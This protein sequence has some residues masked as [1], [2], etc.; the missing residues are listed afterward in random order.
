MDSTYKYPIGALANLFPDMDENIFAGLVRS[1]REDGLREPILVSRGE[2]VDGRHRYRACLE[3]GVE[4]RFER[5][6]DDTDPMSFVIA[7]NILRRQLSPSQLAVIA[8]RLT[9]L[10]LSDAGTD[11]GCAILHKPMTQR[12]A[13]D[14]LGV[15]LRSLH[16][17]RTVLA[18]DSTAAPELR[19]AVE[20]G[21]VTVSDAAKIAKEPPDVQNAALDQV[22]KGASNNLARAAKQIAAFKAHRESSIPVSRSADIRVHPPVFHR[23]AVADLHKF[24]KAGSVDAIIT[25]PPLTEWS[26]VMYSHLADFAVHALTG[27]GCM[28]VMVDGVLLPRIMDAIRRPDLHWVCELDCQVHWP[29]RIWNSQHR[30]T[31]YRRP[32]LVFG[33]PR[34][35]LSGSDVIRPSSPGDPTGDT[36]QLKGFDAAMVSVAR[37]FI[38]P[39]QVVCDPFLLGRGGTA[40]EAITQ[41]CRFIGAD[42]SVSAIERT[43]G[44]LAKADLAGGQDP[45]GSPHHC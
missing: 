38:Q 33:K 40:I 13:A 19:Q 6:P 31:L 23:C 5:L 12:Q 35:R 9:V 15:S 41:G 37:R 22:V 16:H 8:Y 14:L 18:R 11:G 44:I 3:A 30:L 28:V 45:G 17:A 26:I 7:R 4:P 27:S 39:G 34:F 42:P 21:A 2:V 29:Q 36:G 20:R 32:L 24:V 1:I 10:P 43:N 25:H